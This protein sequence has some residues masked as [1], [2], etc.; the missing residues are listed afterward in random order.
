[1]GVVAALGLDHYWGFGGLDV[2]ALARFGAVLESR[3]LLQL[4]C[5][6]YFVWLA[7]VLFHHL[8]W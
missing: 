3:S 7:L 4:T 6:L 8:Y 5:R 1:M 2:L